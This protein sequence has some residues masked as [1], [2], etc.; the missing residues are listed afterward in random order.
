M[1]FLGRRAQA[2]KPNQT[3]PNP[4][5]VEKKYKGNGKQVSLSKQLFPHPSSTGRAIS[6]PEAAHSRE[7]SQMH[8]GPADDDEFDALPVV[9]LGDKK[10][11]ACLV[12]G[13]VK[14][15]DQARRR[16]G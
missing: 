12:T 2:H 5:L 15:E 1:A 14:T 16:P 8:A 13:L 4:A 10:L 7:P 6:S 3:K 11:R 9:P